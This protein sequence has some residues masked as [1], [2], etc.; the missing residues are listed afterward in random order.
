MRIKMFF[1]IYC[2][3]GIS[4]F[5]QRHY[6]LSISIIE[7]KIDNNSL[8][9][10]YKVGVSSLGHTTTALHLLRDAGAAIIPKVENLSGDIL[11]KIKLKKN[12]LYVVSWNYRNENYSKKEV[13]KFIP[14]IKGDSRQT[15]RRR[16]WIQA[17]IG[18]STGLSTIRLYD[19]NGQLSQKINRIPGAEMIVGLRMIRGLDAECSFSHSA[20]ISNYRNKYFSRLAFSLNLHMPLRNSRFRLGMKLGNATFFYYP[21]ERENESNYFVALFLEYFVNARLNVFLDARLNDG[22]VFFTYLFGLKQFF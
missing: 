9:V 3:S 12:K 19:D 20:S 22:D 17:Y 2:L 13:E 14:L 4:V 15:I 6:N 10:K 16:A 11:K 8:C 5:A 21:D 7:K 18:M 1:L